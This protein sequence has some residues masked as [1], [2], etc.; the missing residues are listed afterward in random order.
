MS[1]LIELYTV[2]PLVFEFLI[3]YS[4]DLTLFENL[5][6]KVLV[7][8]LVLIGKPYTFLALNY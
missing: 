1:H 8:A 3:Y 5:Q 2:C 6:T 4:L 7:V